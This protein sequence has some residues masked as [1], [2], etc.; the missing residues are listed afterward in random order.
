M[1]V[2]QKPLLRA[3]Q[4]EKEY[5]TGKQET[6]KVLRGVDFEIQRGEI[7]VI[8]GPSGSGKSTLLHVLGGLDRPTR[9]KVTFDG[10]DLFAMSE[11]EL[12]RFR[13]SAMGFIFQFH[14]LLPEFTALENV[15]MP[16]MIRGGSLR[17]FRDRAAELLHE[18]G[19]ADRLD[20]RPNELSGGEQ[21]RV[22][23]ARALMN[24]PQI[25]FADEPSGNL[26]E[27][28]GV[29]LHNLIVQLAQKHNLTFVIA[30]HNPDLT[31]RADRILRLSDGKLAPLK[32][33]AQRL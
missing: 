27:E 26:D 3:V 8:I 30:T 32:Q 31:K 6:L 9:G 11:K 5:P 29:K 20:H 16:A 17:Q 25:V 12:A 13:N 23:V 22:A 7:V 28:N 15:A 19:L 21:Q 1:G 24:N 10:Q 18:V 2:A 4:L 14:H 33:P